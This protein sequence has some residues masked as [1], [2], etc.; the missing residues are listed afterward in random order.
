M[1]S[2]PPP[3]GLFGEALFFILT[4]SHFEVLVIHY[5]MPPPFVNPGSTT[6]M[7]VCYELDTAA[8]PPCGTCR[9]LFIARLTELEQLV[10]FFI[11][12]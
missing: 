3:K 11:K 4:T 12:V 2:V 7:Y 5:F 9:C 6:G 10:V 1:E 8:I